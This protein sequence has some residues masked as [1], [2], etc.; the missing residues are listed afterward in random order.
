LNI[1]RAVII[2]YPPFVLFAVLH[3]YVIRRRKKFLDTTNMVKPGE[4]CAG[5]AGPIVTA[6]HLS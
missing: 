3:T 4:I 5:A 2:L 6:D 1:V